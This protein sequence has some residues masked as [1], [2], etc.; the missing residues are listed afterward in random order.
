MSSYS[1]LDMETERTTTTPEP[2]TATGAPLTPPSET[3]SV[4]SLPVVSAQEDVEV[5]KTPL[6][7]I[8][9]GILM[10]GTS[11]TPFSVIMSPSF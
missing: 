8:S 5:E 7:A 1:H 2:A 3:S 10:D 4:T 11:P 9:H 6:Q